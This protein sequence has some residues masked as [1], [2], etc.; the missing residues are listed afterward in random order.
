MKTKTERM[1]IRLIVTVAILLLLIV[2]INVVHSSLGRYT[3]FFGG[4]MMFSPNGKGAYSLTSGDWSASDGRQ[5]L[6][7]CVTGNET[8]AERSSFV[9]IR[10][11]VP[12]AQTDLPNILLA[13]NGGEYAGAV[14]NIPE[15]TAAHKSYGAGSICR[16][17]GADG[18]ELS[19]ELP[20]S[21]SESLDM[22]LI[23]ED[24]TVSTTGYR[25]IVEPVNTK[26]GGD[27]S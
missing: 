5:T 3:S 15:G 13:R 16:F 2:F 17:Y 12:E 4:E 19:F 21:L 27:R 9:R 20:D 8:E 18:E 14:S 25:V 26:N 22:T 23:L 24:E 7:L 6:S 11:Y 1:P 10:L